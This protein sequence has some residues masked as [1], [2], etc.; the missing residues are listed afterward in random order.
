MSA[1]PFAGR[2]SGLA[3]LA[4]AVI[5]AGRVT[6]WAGSDS[7]WVFL[8]FERQVPLDT[9]DAVAVAVDPLG[10][11]YLA[12]RRSDKI[13]R[14]N[15][16]LRVDADVGGYGWKR[17]QFDLPVDL[18]AKNGLDVYVCDY[19]NH[20]VERYDKDLHYLASLPGRDLPAP[21][22]FGFPASVAQSSHGD[23]FV[24]DRE[25]VRIVRF[26]ALGQPRLAFG[27]IES[28]A[29]QLTDPVRVDVIGTEQV[30]VL[31]STDRRVVV[32]D[33][34]GN[35]MTS[36][37]E[38]VLQR[39]VGLACTPDGLLLVADQRAGIVAFTNGQRLPV[40]ILPSR[41]LSPFDLDVRGDRLYVLDRREP[42]LILYRVEF[43]RRE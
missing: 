11:V 2:R 39:P 38:Q 1:L 3:T 15:A 28:G 33:F 37:G 12:D 4:F 17:E 19:N 30:V 36:F 8:R 27:N 26:D 23:L 16:E 6:V 7:T 32:F 43:R 25:N 29:G 41:S 10:R 21:W 5:L 31:D 20:R 40:A 9:L 34:F 13:Y 24:A 14:L 22:R 42:S 18:C 35:Y